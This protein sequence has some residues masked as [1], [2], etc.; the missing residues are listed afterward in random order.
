MPYKHSYFLQVAKDFNS[1]APQSDIIDVLGNMLPPLCV[2]AQCFVWSSIL[3]HTDSIMF[4]EELAWF[5]MFVI[6]TGINQVFLYHGN[7]SLLV[8]LSLAH[9]VLYLPWQTLHLKYILSLDDPPLSWCDVTV[10]RVGKGLKRALWYRKQS[11]VREEWGGWIGESWM[12]CYWVV[13]PVWLAAV[14]WESEKMIEG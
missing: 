12:F 3:L 6:N 5:L 11:V 13:M 8:I 7:N 10:S 1:A 14:A 2:L 9:G 4:Y